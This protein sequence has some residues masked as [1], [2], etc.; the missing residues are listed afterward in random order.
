MLEDVSA[1]A[2]FADNRGHLVAKFS[3]DEVKAVVSP[4]T[5]TL[6]LYV[7]GADVGSDTVRVIE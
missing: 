2:V 4:P 1:R 5:A 7:N 6:I 3:E